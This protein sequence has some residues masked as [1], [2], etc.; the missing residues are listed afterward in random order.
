MIATS[1]DLS[2][3]PKR[4]IAARIAGSRPFWDFIMGPS[5][6][7]RVMKIGREYYS[8]LVDM[9]LD[10]NEIPPRARV[11]DVGS[12]PGLLAMALA[13]EHPD[14]VIIGVDHSSAQVRAASSMLS[15][16]QLD[17]CSFRVGNAVDLPFE[18]DSFDIA[19]ST[20]SI[21]CWPD[22]RK[23]LEEIRRVLVGGGEA[24]IIDA[25]SGSTQEEVRL[26]TQGY[27]AGG[28]CR[29]LHEWF[30]RRFVFGRAVAITHRKAE[31]LARDAGFNSIAAEKKPGLPF[32]QLR[33]RK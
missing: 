21:S 8:F 28:A 7:K 23:G 14:A 12:G 2:R 22:M 20:F 30:T 31:E 1:P 13:R 32:F 10:K 6:N 16:S 4:S 11:L 5:Y 26:F 18:S 24:F 25:D 29:S 27:A 3:L 15:S 9:L 33:L 17:N 19:V